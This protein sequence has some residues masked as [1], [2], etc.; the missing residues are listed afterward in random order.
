MGPADGEDFGHDHEQHARALRQA[1]ERHAPTRSRLGSWTLV[2]GT[3]ADSL[4][5]LLTAAEEEPS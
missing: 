1:R 3:S 2:R 4:D 5:E